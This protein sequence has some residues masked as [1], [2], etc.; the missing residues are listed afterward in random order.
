M[1]DNIFIFIFYGLIGY[2]VGSCSNVVFSQP[3]KLTDLSIE[4][5]KYFHG[6]NNAIFDGGTYREKYGLNLEIG[7]RGPY[8]TYNRTKVLS[9]TDDRQFRYIALE[10]E[11]GV[12]VSQFDIYVN[13]KSQ[14][15]MD[16]T[17]KQG[18]KDDNR[19]GLRIHLFK[20][21]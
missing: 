9:A 15:L 1:K 21:K 5:T 13:H 3:I 6:R 20:E 7:L 2:F 10:S 16:A 18:F 8:S 19:V 4:T 11:L 12:S 17:Y 14:H